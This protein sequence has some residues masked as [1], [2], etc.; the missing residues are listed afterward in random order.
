MNA[1]PQLVEKNKKRDCIRTKK[2][3]VSV[4]KKDCRIKMKLMHSWKR[5]SIMEVIHLT[6]TVIVSLAFWTKK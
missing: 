5:F 6:L 1:A 4:I 3:R 2:E